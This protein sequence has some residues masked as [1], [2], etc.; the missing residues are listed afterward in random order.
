MVIWKVKNAGTQQFETEVG[1]RSG[2]FVRNQV[3]ETEG[4]KPEKQCG[5]GLNKLSTAI[6]RLCTWQWGFLPLNRAEMRHSKG[7]YQIYK[8]VDKYVGTKK[9]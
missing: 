5:I 2:N 8:H 7:F 3:K 4:R 6:N 1:F 9:W